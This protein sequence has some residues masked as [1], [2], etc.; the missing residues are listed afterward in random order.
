MSFVHTDEQQM[1]ILPREDADGKLWLY[2]EA[3]AT[4]TAAY[5]VMLS[6]GYAGGTLSVGWGYRADAI[7]NTATASLGAGA[8]VDKMFIGIPNETIES[9]SWGWFQIGGQCDD[10]VTASITGSLGGYFCIKDASV[11]NAGDGVSAS[12]TA[13]VF[14]VCT[15]AASRS[16]VHDMYLCG[17]PMCGIT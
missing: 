7:Y 8:R 3:R 5:P 1:S 17:R 15:V 4:C 10:V 16:T 2:A 9:N 14:A 12:F 6:P 13:N 11:A